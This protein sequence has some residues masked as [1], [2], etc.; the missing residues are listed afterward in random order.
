MGKFS[1]E[2]S[3]VKAQSQQPQNKMGSQ[4]VEQDKN[5]SMDHAGIKPNQVVL[6]GDNQVVTNHN[7]SSEVG[8]INKRADASVF[9]QQ[10]AVGLYIDLN[11]DINPPPS[12]DTFRVRHSPSSFLVHISPDEEA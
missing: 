2:V 6:F 8:D 3:N 4:E 5:N 10:Q 1:N 12:G 11:I 9:S 7:D